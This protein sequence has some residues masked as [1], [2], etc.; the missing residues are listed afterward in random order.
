MKLRTFRAPKG[1]YRDVYKSL[2]L[3]GWHCLGVTHSEHDESWLIRAANK[4]W[5]FSLTPSEQ[6]RIAS[7]QAGPMR[8]LS[9]VL[10]R[11]ENLWKRVKR[12]T[13]SIFCANK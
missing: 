4:A 13:R 8:K 5:F 9:D 1:S 7:A 11:R 2:E 6:R 12:I 3:N 10:P